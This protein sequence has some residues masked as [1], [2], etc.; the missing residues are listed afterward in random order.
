MAST[1]AGYQP[2]DLATSRYDLTTFRGRL[3]HFS[4]ITSPLTLFKS[5][6]Q[7]LEAQK[8]LQDYGKG[9][10]RDLYNP[11]GE[12]Q[13]W[14]AKQCKSLHPRVINFSAD[15]VGEQWWI[16]VYIQILRNLYRCLSEWLLSLQQIWVSLLLS[17]YQTMRAEDFTSV[18]SY[19][20]WYAYAE[21][22]RQSLQVL[23]R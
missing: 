1:H 2:I 9:Q 3:S 8:L 15:H 17:I 7:L 14:K 5:N 10:R 13:V 4:E 22:I 18:D 12:E 16:Q 11:Q 19:C 23:M 20:C 21:P 6:A